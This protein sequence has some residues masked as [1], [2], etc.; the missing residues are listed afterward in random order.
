MSDIDN[1]SDFY[2]RNPESGI[3][4]TNIHGTKLLDMFYLLTESDHS[5]NPTFTNGANRITKRSFHTQQLT[6][7]TQYC[8][9]HII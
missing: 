6:T 3:F 5:Q 4:G 7:N 8:I 2:P 1:L 9:C